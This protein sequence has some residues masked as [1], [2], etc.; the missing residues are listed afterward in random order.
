MQLKRMQAA[1]E[2]A[3][4][5]IKDDPMA[6]VFADMRPADVDAWVEA[7]VHS[8]LDMKDLLKLLLKAAIAS[9]LL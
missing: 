4:A 7:N 8:V 9:N 2:A 1:S 5:G 6:G 3:K